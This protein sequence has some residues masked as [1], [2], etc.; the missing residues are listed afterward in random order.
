MG[1][2]LAH[3]NLSYSQQHPVILHG[4]DPLTKLYVHSQ[5]RLLLHAGP[6][7]LMS[8]VGTSLYIVGARRLVRTICH[9]CVIFR[10]T[11]AV[12]KRQ[13]MGLLPSQRVTPSPPFSRVGIDYACP[14][15]IK[16]GYTRKLVYIKA[17]ICIFMCFVTKTAHLEVVSDLTTE[18]FLA[19]L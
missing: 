17:Y 4:R 1:R 16:K 5:H 3:S 15:I 12:T 13:M 18:A 6:T 2:R 7:L 19:C 8:T 14:L 9:H 10:K 11:A